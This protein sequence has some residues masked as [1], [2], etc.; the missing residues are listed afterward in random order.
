MVE[1]DNQCFLTCVCRGQY[2]RLH[3]TISLN[4]HTERQRERE[5]DR[6]GIRVT[7]TEKRETEAEK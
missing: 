5:T 2:S 4:T 7:D 6:Q 3:S 1:E